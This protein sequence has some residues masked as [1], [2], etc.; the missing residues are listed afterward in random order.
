MIPKLDIIIVNWNSGNLVSECIKSIPNALNKYFILNRIIVVDNASSDDSL[1]RINAE[2]LQVNIIRNKENLGFA[3]AS[4]IGANNSN[5]DYLLFLNPDTK[6]FEN[7]LSTPLIFLE[8]KENSEIGIVGIKIID[9]NGKVSRNCARFPTPFKILYSS[10]GLDKIFPNLFLGHFMVEWNHME[11]RIVDQVMGSFFLIRKNL[12]NQLNGYDE[13]YF[14]YY[15]DLDLAYRAK[16]AGFNSY[17]L[18]TASL[19]HKGGGTTENIKA[20]R[21]Y[22]ILLSKLKFCRKHFS[23]FSFIVILANTFSVEF[24]SRLI[25]T[26]LLGSAKETKEILSAYKKLF[27][28]IL[29][30]L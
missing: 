29:K 21:L 18:D 20:E 9:D 8:K 12:F 4:N 13:R 15:E 17:Y 25:S 3:K 16:I 11:S 10:L 19:Y 14:L 26:T 1:E 6:L 5:S 2:E 27:T 24:F 30:P 23:S 22:L 28:N 7:S